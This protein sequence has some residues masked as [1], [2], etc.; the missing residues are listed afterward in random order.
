MML[1]GFGFKIASA[2]FHMWTPDVY[3][4][5]PTIVTGFMSTGPKAAVFAAFLR[6][7]AAGFAGA[8]P[9]LGAELHATWMTALA[10]IAAIT[11]TVGNVIAISQKNIKRMLAYSS[12][13]H[14]GYALV[15]FVTGEYAPVAFYMLVYCVMSLGAF[16]VIQLLARAGDQKTE[17]G[18]Y[19]GIGFE[20]PGLTFSLSIFLLSLAGI[21]PTAGFM[22]KF[23]V[24]KT[25]W[26]FQWG[27]SHNLRWLV[28]VAVV[29][30][31]ISIYYYLYPI[32]VMFFRP[33]APGFV[34][35]RVSLGATVALIV[36]LF[37]TFYLGILPNRLIDKMGRGSGAAQPAQTQL[38]NR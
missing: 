1:V 3:E 25:A 34:R 5:A 31:I 36:T 4:G 2:P 23:F 8:A 29:N 6:V 13:A 12:I 11:M 26:D 7:F 38:S 27:S 17:I 22:S 30:S 37:G 20:A 15:G 24:F 33:L 28:I 21:P 14:A 10:V 16:A 18:D 35:P 19:A 9:G 32:V